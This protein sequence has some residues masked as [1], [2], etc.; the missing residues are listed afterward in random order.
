MKVIRD[1]DYLD[2]CSMLGGNIRFCRLKRSEPQKILAHHL[3]VSFRM[4]K[5]MK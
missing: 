2:F 5:N 3:G 1:K 4:F